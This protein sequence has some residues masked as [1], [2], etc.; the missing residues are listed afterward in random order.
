VQPEAAVGLRAAW[1][2]RRT[3]RHAGSVHIEFGSNDRAVFWFAVLA[4][5]IRRSNVLVAHDIPKLA[6]VPGSGLIRRR[7]RAGSALAYRVLSPLVDPVVRALV[8]RRARAW[9]VLGDDDVRVWRPLVTGDVR[10]LHLGWDLPDA[11][12]VAPSEGRHVLFAGFIGPSKGV[13]LLVDAWVRIARDDDLPLVIAGDSHMPEWTERLRRRGEAAARPPRWLGALE[14]QAFARLFTDAALVVLP[15][16]FSS[17]ASGILV[18]ALAVGRPVLACRMPALAGLLEDGAQ[19]R[20]VPP[21]DV[22]ALARAMRE[23]LDDPAARDRMGAAAAERARAEL[24]W[25]RH[26]GD[27]DGAYAAARRNAS[28]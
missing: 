12:A 25:D 28:S 1:R 4:C 7:S 16:R 19:G 26:L 21:D 13:D 27:L 23:L 22:E 24:S 6:H 3:I 20:V 8:R 14:E 15:Y 10:R 18:R 17:A 5:L 9:L 11:A 2:A